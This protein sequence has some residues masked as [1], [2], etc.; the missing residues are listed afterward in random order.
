M[1]LASSIVNTASEPAA[2]EIDARWTMAYA[3]ALGDSLPAY[4][5]TLRPA[6]FIAH[7]MFPVCFEWPLIV[8]M[9]GLF[10]TN[11]LTDDEALRCVHENHDFSINR[12]ISHPATLGSRLIYIRDNPLEPS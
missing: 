11:L 9:R 7:P 10:K 12:A 2:S 8:A 5:D 1:P 4:M 3:A 6:D